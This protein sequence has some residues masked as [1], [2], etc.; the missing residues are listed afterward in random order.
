VGERPQPSPA[1]TE[2]EGTVRV[3]LVLRW[4]FRVTAVAVVLAVFLTLVGFLNIAFYDSEL[5]V[6]NRFTPTQTNYFVIGARAFAPSLIY[7]FATIVVLLV[8]VYVAELVSRLLRAVPRVRTG[9]NETS[10]SISAQTGRI[11][12]AAQPTGVAHVFF[13][14]AVLVTAFGVARYIP[15]YEA[16][17]TADSAYLGC[18]NRYTLLALQP[19]MTVL[20]SGLAFG[21]FHVFRWVKERT[22]ELRSVAAPRWGSAG[23]ILL[24][25]LVMAVP[26]RLTF[27]TGQERVRIGSD[28]GYVLREN[29]THLV[30]YNADQRRTTAYAQPAAGVSRLGVQGNVFEEPAIFASGI[31]ECESVGF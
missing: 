28:R 12:R 7:V 22:G 13:L 21:W 14:L 29:D 15:L 8:L 5:Q 17:F 27:L 9:L 1:A 4:A 11:V 20:I 30:V 26:W 24:L 23:L 10:Q 19:L 18:N 16:L 3:P 6:P 31:Q 25:T 2:A